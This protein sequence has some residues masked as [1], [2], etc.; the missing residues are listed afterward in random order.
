MDLDL[1]DWVEKEVPKVE[2]SQDPSPKSI[3]LQ[4]PP[5]PKIESEIGNGSG[6]GGQGGAVV[7]RDKIGRISPVK[8][9]RWENPLGHTSPPSLPSATKRANAASKDKD[10]F[11]PTRPI[12]S[13]GRNGSTLR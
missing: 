7:G 1:K 11:L 13:P 9:K 5:K 4:L 2:D 10:A 12:A 3:T 6:S 8:G